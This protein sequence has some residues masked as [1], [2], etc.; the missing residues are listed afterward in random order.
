LELEKQRQ[1]KEEAGKKSRSLELR[2]APLKIRGKA[3]ARGTPL[4]MTGLAS[5]GRLRNRVVIMRHDLLR[6]YK[7]CAQFAHRGWP[8]ARTVNTIAAL[9]RNF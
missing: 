9:T 5:I 7:I 2:P 8:R 6:R 3:K 1:E 4:G